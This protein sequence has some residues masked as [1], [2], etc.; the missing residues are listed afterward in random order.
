MKLS[1]K[2][3]SLMERIALAL[4]L[5]PRPLLDTQIAFNSARSI[6]AAAELGVFEALGQGEKTAEEVAAHC[7]T[8]AGATKQLLNCLVGIGYARWSGGKYGMPRAL[9]KWLLRSSPNSMVDKLAFQSMEWDL[10]GKLE[11]FVRSGQSIDFHGSMS[12]EQWTIYQDAMRDVS[13]G[14]AVELAKR[15]PVPAGAT[16]LLDIGGSHGL[17]SIELC[18]RH[19]ALQSTI[20]ELPG[21]IDRASAIAAREGM[22]DR[23]RHRAG[24]A[25]TDDLGEATYDVVMINNVAH[26]FTPAQ[27]I[28]LAKRVKRALAPG[29]IYAVGEFLRANTPGKGGAVAATMDFYFALTSASGTWS[30]EEIN[31]WQRAA[32]LAPLKPIQFPSLPGWA[33]APARR[34]G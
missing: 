12:P 8:H 34:E 17:Y 22:A 21:A 27:N 25:L 26:H 18:R 3:E 4:N 9:R 1:A 31:S 13:A 19:P 15:L 2:P 7:R 11:G 6:M 24:N 20:L 33:V 14:P 28:D 16:R 30:L 29:G 10:M 5:A 32:D 23:V